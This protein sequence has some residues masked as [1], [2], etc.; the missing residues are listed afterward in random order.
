MQP[1][2]PG[3]PG[4][5]PVPGGGTVQGIGDI[6]YSLFFSPVDS[7][8]LIWGVVPSINLPTATDGAIGS[9]KWSLGPTAVFLTQSKPWIFGALVRQLWSVGGQSGRKEVSQLAF[10]PFV[11]Y[12]LDDGWYLWT[13]PTLVANWRAKDKWTVPLGGGFGR[14]FSVGDQPINARIGGEYNVI[15][16]DPA[17]E[18]SIKFTFQFLFPK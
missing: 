6:N 1:G 11:N 5:S 10:Q 15:R 2:L 17:P 18:W 8:P 9:G 16:P 3:V 12:N 13:S 7:G 4:I 14:I